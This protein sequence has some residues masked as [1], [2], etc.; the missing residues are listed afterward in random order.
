MSNI[1]LDNKLVQDLVGRWVKKVKIFFYEAGC[2]GTKVDMSEDFDVDE[3]LT[4][5][6]SPREREKYW[7][8]I[9]VEKTDADKFKG[10]TITRLVKADHTGKEKVRYILSSDKVQDRCGC[11]ASFSFEKKVPKINLENLKNLKNSFQK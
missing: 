4:P 5:T 10:V 1:K 6:L 11:G 7:F 2:S 8:Q 9:Y 3:S